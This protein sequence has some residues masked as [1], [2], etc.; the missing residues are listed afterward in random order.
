MHL[1]GGERGRQ[2][3][4]ERSHRGAVGAFDTGGVLG[5]Q[6]VLEAHDTACSVG[7]LYKR[8][9]IGCYGWLGLGG[10]KG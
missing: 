4:G 2:R 10:G 3:G 9:V 8:G 7:R 1:G 5:P 6:G